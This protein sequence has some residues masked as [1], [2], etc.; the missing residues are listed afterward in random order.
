MR[1]RRIRILWV[2]VAAWV[3][4]ALGLSVMALHYFGFAEIQFNPRGILVVD[5]GVVVYNDGKGWTSKILGE[6][7]WKCGSLAM[8]SWVPSSA[9]HNPWW[10]T[11]YWLPKYQ[12]PEVSWSGETFQVMVPGWLGFLFPVAW[13]GWMLVRRRRRASKGL[14]LQCAYNLR[15]LHTSACPECG[16][17]LQRS[18]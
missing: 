15:G 10:K 9:S 8:F 2:G 18:A 16:A 12:K 11:Y 13:H 6:G 4:G 5:R 14:C 1:R 3:V 17:A 7:Q